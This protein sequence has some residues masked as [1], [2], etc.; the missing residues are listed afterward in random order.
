LQCKITILRCNIIGMSL[1]FS[2]LAPAFAGLL[3]SA[4]AVPAAADDAVEMRFEGFGPAGVHVMT[5]RT[6]IEENRASYKID[7]ELATAGLG[8]LF[9]NVANRSVTEGQEAG[10]VPHPRV[11]DSETQRN[12]ITVHNRVDYRLGSLPSGS[13]T[14]PPADPVTPV[15]ASQLAGTVDGLTAYLLVERQV[16]HGG[17]CTLKVPVFDGRHRYDLEFRDAGNVALAPKDGQRYTGPA[18]ECRMTRNEIG[19]FYVDKSHAEGASAGVIWYAPLLS[20]SDLAVPVRMEMETE[21]G[22]VAMFLSRL[23]GRGIDLKLMD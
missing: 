9:A 2:A 8:A 13:S 19:G 23:R 5:S 16:A 17:S 3:L 14:P 15:E 10:D 1:R 4:A 18:H 6:V 12:G 22:S 11:F 21:I 7:G 20:E